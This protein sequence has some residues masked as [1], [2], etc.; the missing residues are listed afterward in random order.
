VGA[1]QVW[2]SDRISN[3]TTRYNPQPHKVGG[4]ALPWTELG[5]DYVPT[6]GHVRHVFKNGYWD[7]GVYAADPFISV[8]MLANVFHYGQ[9]I[10]EGFK[11]YHTKDGRVCSFVDDKSYARMCH[12]ARRFQM[13]EPS[14][15]MWQNAV[16]EAVRQNCAFIPPYESN[17]ALYV[18]PFLF[19]SGPKLGLGPSS[20]YTFMVFVNPVGSYYKSGKM[21]PL[22]GLVNDDFDRVAPLGSGDVKA[23]GNYAADLESMVHAKKLGFPISL[24]LD[25][26]ERRYIEEFNTSNFIAIT[27]DGRYVT[28]LNPRTILNSCTNQVLREIAADMGLKVEQRKID[29]E[30]EVDTFA[31]VGAVGTAVVVTPLASLTRGDKTWTFDAPKVLLELHDR[32]RGIQKGE[33]EDKHGW[34]REIQLFDQTNQ[35][36]LSIYPPL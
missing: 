5:F 27:K 17:G 20:E 31:E 30:A 13:A 6:N 24:Y 12:G 29:F 8:H 4:A 2:S 19:G 28:P 1:P 34:M 18:R 23:A 7:E 32:V 36:L 25:G 3:T 26:A 35:S 33:I 9:S 15:E 21:Q 22:D 16:D 10:F 11:V 14:R